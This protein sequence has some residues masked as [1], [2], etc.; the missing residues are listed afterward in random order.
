MEQADL[1]LSNLTPNWSYLIHTHF[2]YEPYSFQLKALYSLI[3][4]RYEDSGRTGQDTILYAPTS[5]RK[6]LIS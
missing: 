4:G 5:A 3:Y 2:G 1:E 6:S